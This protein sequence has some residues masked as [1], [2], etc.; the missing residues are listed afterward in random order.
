ML[1]CLLLGSLFLGV[2]SPATD[3]ALQTHP[4]GAWLGQADAGLGVTV[5]GLAHLGQLAI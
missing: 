5:L 1:R 3:K 2:Q 4:Q